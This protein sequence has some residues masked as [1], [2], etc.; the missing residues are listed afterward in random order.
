MNQTFRCNNCNKI[1]VKPVSYFKKGL[2]NGTKVFYC[3]NDCHFMFLKKEKEQRIIEKT[4]IKKCKY[5]Q[6]EFETIDNKKEFCSMSCSTTYYNKLY[7][8]RLKEGSKI[9][10][11]KT[12]KEYYKTHKNPSL[13]EKIKKDCPIC[14]KEFEVRP[15]EKNKI[16]CSK[17]CY[18]D[19][20]K[21]KFRTKA[22]GGV[23]EG[24]G[25]GKHGWY[26]GYWC[27]SS[28]ELA[29][30]IY[31][32]DHNIKFVRNK[33]GFEYEFENKKYKYYPDFILEDGTY[34]EI[35]AVLNKKN[36]AKIESFNKKLT[37]IDKK[38]IQQYIDYVVEKYGKN[39]IELYEGNPYNEKLNS[40]LICGKPAKNLYCSRKCSGIGMKRKLYIVGR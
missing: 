26:K 8:S 15:C 40:C 22:S 5:C 14:N 39:F 35:K 16:Y 11:S 12:L 20:K 31:N 32:I 9:K 37:I 4:V 17:Q 2:K 25:Y 18:K 19:D 33:E 13:K 1:I 27:D 7:R 21:L 34:V 24:A 23:R 3:S 30:V 29:Y 6:K 28:W 38:G 10:I 36:K